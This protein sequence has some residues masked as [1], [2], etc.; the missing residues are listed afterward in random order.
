RPRLYH[1][2]R[3]GGRNEIDLLAELGV[4]RVIGFEVKAASAPRGPD[5]RHL[6]WLRDELGDRFVAGVV[7]HTGPRQF[8]MGERITALPMWALWS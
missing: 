6:A 5:A 4:D 2:R 1:L 8:Q 7:F 3:D